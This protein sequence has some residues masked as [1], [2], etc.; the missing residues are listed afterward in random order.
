[1]DPKDQGREEKDE[2]E[3][4]LENQPLEWADEDRII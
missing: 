1:M 2:A 3:E 4:P